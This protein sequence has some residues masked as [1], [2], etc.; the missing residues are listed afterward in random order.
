MSQFQMFLLAIVLS[1]YCNHTSNGNF[2]ISKRCCPERQGNVKEVLDYICTTYLKYFSANGNSTLE[3]DKLMEN[4]VR[5][6]TF[7]N[8]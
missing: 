4:G 7:D 5:L 6:E 2:T 8:F 3:N 1:T